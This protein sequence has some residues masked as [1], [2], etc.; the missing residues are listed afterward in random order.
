MSFFLF[1]YGVPVPKKQQIS[2]LTMSQ[3]QSKHSFSLLHGAHWLEAV[4]Q[5]FCSECR[6]MPIFLHFLCFGPNILWRHAMR[7]AVVGPAF[8]CKRLCVPVIYFW[9][10]SEWFCQTSEKSVDTEHCCYGYKRL[11][12]HHKPLLKQQIKVWDFVM[13]LC[14]KV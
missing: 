4:L 10:H 7:V 3:T 5:D 8:T 1:P 14:S 12:I 11:L 6:L 13:T 2:V 9:L